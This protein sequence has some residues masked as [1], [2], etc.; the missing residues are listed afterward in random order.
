MLKNFSLHLIHSLSPNGIDSKILKSNAHNK[1]KLYYKK[2]LNAVNENS[3]II[4]SLGR[5]HKVKG[6][7][8]LI[9]AFTIVKEIYNNCFLFIAGD[10]FGEK[11]NLVRQN[12]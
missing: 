5:L 10:D 9:D 11:E 6:F 3:V 1:D 8:I 4:V 7:D 12:K 2:Y